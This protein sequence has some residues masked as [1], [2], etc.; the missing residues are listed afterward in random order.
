M[1]RI[2][3]CLYYKSIC[4]SFD[5]VHHGDR[6]ETKTHKAFRIRSMTQN[7]NQIIC[8][9]EPF[10]LKRDR[11]SK[12]HFNYVRTNVSTQVTKKSFRRA[13]IEKKAEGSRRR[14]KVQVVLESSFYLIP[15]AWSSPASFQLPYLRGCVN[16][17]IQKAS[18]FVESVVKFIFLLYDKKNMLSSLV[19]IVVS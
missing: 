2:H 9:M 10:F 5:I 11:E 16:G 19:L 7:L 8:E 14:N 6:K 17:E 18:E 4:C 15:R 13:A 3:T 12:C 1:G